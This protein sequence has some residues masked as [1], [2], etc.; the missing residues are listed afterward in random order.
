MDGDY[1][2]GIYCEGGEHRL[3][4]N[5]CDKLYIERFHKNHLKSRTHIFKIRKT[6][7]LNKSYEIISLI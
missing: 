6:E 3:Y 7:Q 5:I 4:G 2:E 1:Q